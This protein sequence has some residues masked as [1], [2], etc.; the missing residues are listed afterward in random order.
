MTPGGAHLIRKR[1][2]ALG[3]GAILL[4]LIGFPADANNITQYTVDNVTYYSNASQNDAGATVAAARASQSD[5][6]QEVAENFEAAD[7]TPVAA[8]TTQAGFATVAREL[9]A[10]VPQRDSPLWTSRTSGAKH[11]VAM[12]LTQEGEARLRSGDPY[13]ALSLFEKALGLEASPYV[14]VSL[15]RA[16][17]ML[18]HYSASLN[19]I[20]VAESWLNQDSNNVPEVAAFKAQVPGSGLTE[21]KLPEPLVTAANG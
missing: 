17:Y 13:R 10:F 5:T 20:E 9:P 4:F 12:K 18:G 3:S 19:F 14:Y 7:R 6:K 21:Q 8:V 16:H 1:C 15:A 11:R 2:L